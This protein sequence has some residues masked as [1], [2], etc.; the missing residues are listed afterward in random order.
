MKAMIHVD[1]QK[2][3]KKNYLVLQYIEF[4]CEIVLRVDGVFYET[5]P[6]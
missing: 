6:T 5:S 2:K 4:T 3:K 1:N